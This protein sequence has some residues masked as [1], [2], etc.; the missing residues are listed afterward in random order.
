MD[1]DGY[2]FAARLPFAPVVLKRPDQLFL[3]GI[4]RDDE[5]AASAEDVHSIVDKC[6]LLVPIRMRR[7]LQRLLCRLQAL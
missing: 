5:G 7:P 2:R 6:K 1:A 4:H 3:L